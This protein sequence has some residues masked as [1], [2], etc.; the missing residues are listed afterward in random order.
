MPA[1]TATKIV[2]DGPIIPRYPRPVFFCRPC[3]E[4]KDE[5]TVVFEEMVQ[6]R[7]RSFAP[8]RMTWSRA[9][10]MQTMLLQID[11][12]SPV[13]ILRKQHHSAASPFTA[14]FEQVQVSAS[15]DRVSWERRDVSVREQAKEAASA[16]ARADRIQVTFPLKP[17]D[18]GGL[19]H[20]ILKL[21]VEQP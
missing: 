15:H 21:R 19:R 18:V 7:E 2:R 9:R 12:P 1:A 13:Q 17:A 5:I 16:A 6:T 4:Q 8:L 14:S 11:P 3:T 20:A 10:L